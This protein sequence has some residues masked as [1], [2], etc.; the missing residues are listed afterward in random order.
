MSVRAAVTINREEADVRS[1]WPEAEAPLSSQDAEVSY[2]P[3]PGGRGTEV[4]V[5]LDKGVPG[6]VV[7]EKLASVLGVNPQQQLDDALR[8]FKQYVETGEVVRSDGSPAGT[9]AKQQRAQRKA[10]PAH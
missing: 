8:R 2:A 5:V 10:Q 6:G 1:L 3:A 4:R 9:D 7:G